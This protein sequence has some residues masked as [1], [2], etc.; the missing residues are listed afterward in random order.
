LVFARTINFEEAMMRTVF[1]GLSALTMPHMILT[2]WWHYRSEPQPGDLFSI[3]KPR[4]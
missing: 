2:T 1:W 3:S 4:H